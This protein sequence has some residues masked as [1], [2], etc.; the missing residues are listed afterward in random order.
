MTKKKKII[1]I[2]LVTLFVLIGCGGVAVYGML[3]DVLQNDLDV[4]N[5]N[6]NPDLAE[7]GIKNIAIF[8]I[9]GREEDGEFIGDRSDAI[10]I[11]SCNFD[12][13][14]VKVVS[15]MRDLMVEIADTEVSDAYLTKI[16]SAFAFGG[17][18]AQIATLNKNFDLNIEDYVVVNFDCMIDVVDTLGGVDVNIVDEEM[19]YWVDCYI[20]TIIE[21]TGKTSAAVPGTGWQHLNGV[22]TL[23]YCR[24]RYSDSDYGRTARQREVVTKIAEKA[25]DADLLTILNLMRKVYPYVTTSL[26]ISEMTELAT[27][28]LSME[29]KTIETSRVPFDTINTTGTVDELSF[30]LPTS[31]A[32]NVKVLHYLF[33]GDA[34]YTPS[35]TV[36]NIS[37]SIINYTGYGS[38][39]YLTPAEILSNT[40]L[41]ESTYT[42]DDS[43]TAGDSDADL[44][45]DS[46]E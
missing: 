13:G 30:V 23:A 43:S 22:Q 6:I 36:Q 31:L 2:I 26:S 24:N 44:D 35:D 25:M 38:T 8:G 40:S 15:F 29:N 5:L 16:N 32:D 11:A 46:E 37:D 34:N 33:Y 4:N 3:H 21:I 27:A 14:E 28:Y 19:E 45:A 10:L 39:M 1:C 17:V 42:G 12:T 41:D 20:G 7:S 18:E 9:D